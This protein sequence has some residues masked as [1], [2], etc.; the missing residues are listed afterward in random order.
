MDYVVTA[1]VA[2]FAGIGVGTFVLGAR[3]RSIVAEAILYV[4]EEEAAAKGKVAE[5][6][7]VL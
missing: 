7:K 1:L 5:V 6:K 2:F 4:R 3:I